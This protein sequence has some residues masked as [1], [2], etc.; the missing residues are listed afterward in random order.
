[1]KD[2]FQHI[3]IPILNSEY[4][5][6][7]GWGNEK[8]A[9]PWLKKVI[10]PTFKEEDLEGPRGHCWSSGLYYCVPVLYISLPTK[11]KHFLSTVAH[12]A[13]HALNLIWE[14]IAEDSKNEVYA[15]SIGYIVHEVEKRIR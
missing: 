15:H 2:T 14:Y 11:D 8:Q 9:I 7:L 3:K 10:G 4:Y 12:E 6:L 5:V 13:V 1:M